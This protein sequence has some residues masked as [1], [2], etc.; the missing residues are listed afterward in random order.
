M[1]PNK[2]AIN[3]HLRELFLALIVG[4]NLNLIIDMLNNKD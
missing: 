4:I 3:N 2:I 1:L